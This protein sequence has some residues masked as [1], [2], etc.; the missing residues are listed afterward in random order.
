MHDKET[1]RAL[2]DARAGILS[3][4]S[5]ASRRTG[6]PPGVENDRNPCRSMGSAS[7]IDW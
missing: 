4:W 2:T 1:Y 5:L 7:I 6:D 3:G